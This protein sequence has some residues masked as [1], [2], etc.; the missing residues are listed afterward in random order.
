[1]VFRRHNGVISTRVPLKKSLM[2]NR[3]ILRVEHRPLKI[4]DF[5]RITVTS[6]HN[7][8]IQAG[9]E[10]WYEV[11]ESVIKEVEN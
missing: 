11:I 9:K 6:F 4:D 2:N 7:N 3:K 8:N 1:M 5:T 10:T